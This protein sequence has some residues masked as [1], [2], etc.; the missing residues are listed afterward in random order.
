[1]CEGCAHPIEWHGRF[2][3]RGWCVVAA[4]R[5]WLTRC[6]CRRDEAEAVQSCTA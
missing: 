4:D 1:M 3:C 2:G 6:A 5:E